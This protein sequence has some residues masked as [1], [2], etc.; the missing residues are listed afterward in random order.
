MPEN[1]LYVEGSIICRL[2]MGTAGLQP[3]RLNRVIVLLN[4]H[5]DK[6]FLYVAVNSVSA[7]RA[8][9]GLRCARTL[10]MNPPLV[11]KSAYSSAGVAEGRADGMV[12]LLELLDKYRNEYD[13][14]AIVSQ[15]DV[16]PEYHHQYFQS[17][18]K[19]VNPWGGVE[20]MLTH[21]I[22]LLCDVPSAHL[23][24]LETQEIADEEPGLVDPRMA[25]E[26]ISLGFLECILKG[27]HR[28][29]RIVS[30]REAMRLPGV[31]TANDVSY[32]VI[33]DGVF[34]LPTLAAL[35]QGIPVIAVR[36]N[37]NLMRNDLSALPR[38]PG[39]YIPVANYW[40]AAGVMCAL[41]AG[42]APESVRRPLAATL[43]NGEPLTGMALSQRINE[44]NTKFEHAA[45][46]SNGS[47]GRFA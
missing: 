13:A 20:A 45:Q 36:E 5:Q 30:E 17:G 11:M 21:A 27:L 38:A 8:V 23:P 26:A 32:L 10:L 34:G 14:V 9:F 43:I 6:S 31:I 39:Q 41:K 33:P 47:N 46:G 3:V 44:P 16:P 4:A 35:E 25:A 7:A 42:I 15:I 29:P 37:A 28:A 12:T 22:S 2:M 1:A 18:G 40:E 24:M 19:M